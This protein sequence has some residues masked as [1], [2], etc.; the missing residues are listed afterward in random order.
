MEKLKMQTPDLTDKNIE[1][2]AKLFPNVITE[3]KD[4]NGN[5]KKVVDFD[6]LKQSLS[7]VL[8]ED[9]DERYRLDWPGKKASLLKA[10]TPINKTLRPVIEDSVDFENTKNVFIEGDNFEVLKILQE[11]YLGKIKMIYIDPPYNTGNDLIYRDNFKVNK[12]EYEEEIGAVDENGEKLFINTDSNGRFHSDWLS[13]INERLIVARDLLKDNGVIFIS[14]DDN[15]V[16]N[17]KKICDEVF[18]EEN[19]VGLF[20]IN[21]SPSA[22]DYGHIAKTNDYA[23]FYSKNIEST[24]TYQLREENKIFKY[25]DDN[26]PFNL[27]PLYNGNVAFNPKTRPNLYYPFYLNPNNKFDKDFYE[28]GL[29]KQKGWIEVYPVVSKKDKI[30][31]VWRWGKTKAKENLNQEIVGYCNE[32]GEYRVVQKTRHTGKVI[33]SLQLDK[34]ISS[35]RG[36]GEVE[37]LFNS[38]LFSFPKPIELIKRFTMISTIKNDLILDF[39]AGSATTAHAV[40]ELNA[41]DG[42]KRKFILVQLPEKTN[43]DSA[44]Y[45]AGYKTISE[46]GKERIRRAGKKIKKELKL[47]NKQLKLGEE[48]VD[49]EKLDIGFRVY[50]TDSSNMKD[51]FYHPAELKQDQLSIL[52]SNIKEDRGPEDI[53]SQVILDLGLELSLPIE[54]KKIL[55]N[56]VFIV[57]QNALVACFDDD[58]NFKIVDKFA[59]LKPFKVVFKDASFKD[60]KDRIN[61]EERFKRLSPETVIMVI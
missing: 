59:E 3:I 31:R 4:D 29:E 27:Y 2:I 33:R 35:R 30:Q 28:I 41:E 15:E 57:Q 46:I 39:F 19:F 48:Q 43:E 14:I 18:G 61:V 32:N 10:N 5:T 11:S 20:I 44:A 24:T 34:D 52:E 53:L 36:T 45:K 8:V 37:N 58:I 54:K 21:S 50:K 6:L 40:M 9:D 12:D 38:K 60:D 25:M 13:M 56:T 47:K 42:A 55:G 49:V 26:G 1:Q 23:L 7:D 51:V 16:Y 17:L 22:I